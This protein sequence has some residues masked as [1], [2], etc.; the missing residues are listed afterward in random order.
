MHFIINIQLLF[1]YFHTFYICMYLA[2]IFSICLDQNRILPSQS[3]NSPGDELL[4]EY[5][6]QQHS[7]SLFT[8]RNPEVTY[9]YLNCCRHQNAG[10]LVCR[11]TRLPFLF[12][13]FHAK[14]TLLHN[15]Q[16]YYLDRM[17]GT[18]LCCPVGLIIAH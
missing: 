2:F 13:V 6:L 3:L 14:S 12:S 9:N 10:T 16:P 18:S 4:M 8:L 17:I 1:T 11:Y 7:E 5:T 15:Y